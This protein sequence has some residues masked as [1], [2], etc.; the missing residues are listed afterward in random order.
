MNRLLNFSKRNFKEILRDPL[1]YIFCLGFPAVM[2]LLFQIISKYSNGHTPMFELSS[3]LPAI[4]MFS[5]TFV[6]LTMSLLVSKDKQTFFLK[7]LYS[8]PMKAHHFVFGY[9]I[10][11]LTIGLIQT[12]VCI[13]T[14]FAIALITNVSLISFG[15]IILLTISQFPILIT[16]IFLGIL[17]GT[18]LNDKSAPG[19]CSIFI[20]VAGILGGCWMPIE[21][22]GSFETFCKFLPFY[23]SVYIGRIITNAHKVLNVSY[24][25]DSTA[26]WGIAAIAI[27][28]SVS[29]VATYIIF[30][31]NM[32]SDK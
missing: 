15:N 25:F 18:L 29:I 23:P 12:T 6:M 31:K 13:L 10:V 9:A 27:Y 1:I 26:I 7:R 20:S 17:F 21:T 24:T 16:N 11:G 5:Y 2:L 8:S 28:M 4:L 3:L 19:I 32:V 30:I 14:A 22:M